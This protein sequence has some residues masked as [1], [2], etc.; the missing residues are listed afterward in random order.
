MRAP[1]ALSA[2]WRGTSLTR[3]TATCSQN[4]RSFLGAA[5]LSMVLQKGPK[6]STP[7]AILAE[8]TSYPTMTHTFERLKAALAHRSTIGGDSVPVEW[9]RSTW[10]RTSS[11]NARWL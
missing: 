8:V 5:F 10:P 11:T 3:C 2:F 9:L 4:K 6:L 7:R 1:L